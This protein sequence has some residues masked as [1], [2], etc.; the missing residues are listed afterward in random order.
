MNRTD[1]L[2]KLKELLDSGVITEN[3]F[4][5]KKAELFSD[6]NTGNENSKKKEEI[7][8]GESEKECPSCKCIIDKESEICNFCDYDFINNEIR[9]EI[10]Y[11]IKSN[12]NLKKYISVFFLVVIFIFLGTWF[13]TS[14]NFNRSNELELKNHKT[15]VENQQYELQQKELNAQK[16]IEAAQDS[17]AK[18]NS[19][20][21]TFQPLE[22]SVPTDGLLAFW[23]FNGNANDSSK[24]GNNGSVYGATL[25]NDRFGNPHSAYHFNGKD[26]Y[27]KTDMNPPSGNS[28]RSISY[29]IQSDSNQS[30]MT[31]LGYGND[32]SGEDFHIWYNTGCKGVGINISNN[33]IT[34][35]I[36]LKNKK[37]NH[38]CFVYDNTK[39]NTASDIEIYK[40]GELLSNTCS[41]YGSE[42]I[43]TGNNFPLTI[44]KYHAKD[45]HYL[46]G[47]LDDIGIWNRALSQEEISKLYLGH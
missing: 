37:W 14:N 5:R 46:E 36:G 1:E 3:D 32:S 15:E 4:K 27:I 20:K 26:N 28:S 23:S 7:I 12:I 2:L 13:F 9:E 41:I 45:L 34:Y 47:N 43:N 11:P 35:D 44:G 42:N 38:Y 17:I 39:G 19:T 18:I 22:S 40:N 24:N 10:N 30:Y 25:I 33:A 8:V 29:W 16:N 21:N 31:V 6:F